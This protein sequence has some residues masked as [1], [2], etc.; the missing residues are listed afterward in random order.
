MEINQL[1]T[2]TVSAPYLLRTKYSPDT[3]LR[4]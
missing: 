1:H 4:L 2:K 3:K